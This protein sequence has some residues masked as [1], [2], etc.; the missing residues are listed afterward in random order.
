VQSQLV[1][2]CVDCG[3]YFVI[4]QCLYA[5]GVVPDDSRDFKGRSRMHCFNVESVLNPDLG[6]RDWWYWLYLYW[7]IKGVNTTY[8]FKVFFKFKSDDMEWAFILHLKLLSPL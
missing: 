6:K 5:V 7:N 4:A 1:K 2:V 3:F 8:I